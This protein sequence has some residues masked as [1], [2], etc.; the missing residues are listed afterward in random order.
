MSSAAF[1]GGTLRGN[2]QYGL[3]GSTSL[4]GTPL[5]PDSTLDPAYNSDTGLLVPARTKSPTSAIT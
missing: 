2:R 1:L 3:V 5:M 4:E